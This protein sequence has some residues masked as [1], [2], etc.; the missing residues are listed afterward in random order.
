MLL[1]IAED[2]KFIDPII[3]KLE[4]IAPGQN[5]YLIRIPYSDYELKHI[6]S[7]KVICTTYGS[8]QYNVI[9][10]KYKNCSAIIFHNFINRYKWDLIKQIPATTKKVWI[11]WGADLYGSAKLVNN[12]YKPLT[13][14][15]VHRIKK[16]GYSLKGPFKNI[17]FELGSLFPLKWRVNLG[18]NDNIQNYFKYFD[19]LSPI[20]Y[21]DYLSLKQKYPNITIKHLPFNYD[22]Q[23]NDIKDLNAQIHIGTNII[24]GNSGSPVNNH[25]DIFDKLKKIKLFTD[26]KIIVPLSYGGDRQYIEEIMNKGKSYFGNHFFPIHDFMPMKEYSEL[27]KTVGYGF[28]NSLRQHAMGNIKIVMFNG[29]KVFMDERNPAFSFFRRINVKLYSLN[30]P[31]ESLQRELQ[32][33]L[34]NMEI[35]KNREAIHNRFSGSNYESLLKNFVYTLTNKEIKEDI[36]Y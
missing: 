31:L 18:I 13:K 17:L 25:L 4:K 27:L 24:I 23:K 19:Y 16:T 35:M 21:E 2:E 6:R 34:S 9:I 26:Q 8:E 28:F 29:G 11:A 20:I 5:I 10:Q 7:D 15:H 1:H 14:K 30:E 32:S 33:Q 3:E 22:N 36:F 12:L